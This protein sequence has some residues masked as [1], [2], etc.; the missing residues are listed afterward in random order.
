MTAYTL[1]N[2]IL[3]LEIVSSL[4]TKPKGFLTLDF[5]FRLLLGTFPE[6]NFNSIALITPLFSH[7]YSSMNEK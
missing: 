6:K 5:M 4:K 1:S 7:S 3:G 2:I